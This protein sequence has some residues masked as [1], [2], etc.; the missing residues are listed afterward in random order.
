LISNLF[1][2]ETKMLNS[3]YKFTK[4]IIFYIFKF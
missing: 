2:D 3:K 4:I 1:C